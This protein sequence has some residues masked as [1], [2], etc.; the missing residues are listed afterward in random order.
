MIGDVHGCLELLERMLAQVPQDHRI[1]LAGDYIDRGEQ[2]AEVLRYLCAR[3]ELT[4]LKGNHEDMLLRFL[5]DPGR[6]GGRW[7]RNGGL[8]TLA[9][10]GVPGVRPQMSAAALRDCR[11]HLQERMGAA[12][13][14]WAAGLEAS[15]VS[16]NVLAAH[17]GADPHTA[18]DRQAEEVLMWGHPAFL[19][20]PRRD[21]VWV[22]H[23]H[24][25][26]A[27]AAAAQG[28]I[29]IDTGAYASGILSAVCLA[30]GAVRFLQARR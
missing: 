19:R 13:I 11:D 26:V 8:Q 10:F 28:R 30:D 18:A 1:V 7:I 9:S 15:L 25:I 14:A 21:G 24:T 16:G 5:R 27:E 17:A 3:P 20:T 29:A 12:L 23:G 22:V 6:E 4:C 2:S